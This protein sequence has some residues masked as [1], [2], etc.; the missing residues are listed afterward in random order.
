MCDSVDSA[1]ACTKLLMGAIYMRVSLEE[2]TELVQMP[3]EKQAYLHK[4]LDSRLEHLKTLVVKKDK[5]RLMEVEDLDTQVKSLYG[6]GRAQLGHE[7]GEKVCRTLRFVLPKTFQNYLLTQCCQVCGEDVS[8]SGYYSKNDGTF[9][10][11]KDYKV[12]EDKDTNP[13]MDSLSDGV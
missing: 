6:S 5:R 7:S 9:Y 11:F 1:L 13:Q 4:L 3:L 8:G 10:C 2:G 12:K